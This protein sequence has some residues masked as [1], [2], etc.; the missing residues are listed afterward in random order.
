[1]TKKK[2]FHKKLIRDRIPEVIEANNGEYETRILQDEEFEKELRNKLVEEAQEVI[3]AEEEGLKNELADIL[4]L[5]KSIALHHG[6][7]FNEIEKYQKEKREKRGGF[8]RKIF[9]IW[10]TGK[11]GK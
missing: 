2:I 10:S 3:Q 1:M 4:E 7:R 9:L 5:V 6:I 8:K 11:S